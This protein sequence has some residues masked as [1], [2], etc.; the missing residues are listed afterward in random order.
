M[1]SL[2]LGV[3][4]I[5]LWMISTW[6]KPATSVVTAGLAI[7]CR[8]GLRWLFFRGPVAVRFQ[9]QDQFWISLRKI[10]GGFFNVWKVEKWA[11]TAKNDVSGNFSDNLTVLWYVVAM[12]KRIRVL[13]AYYHFVP[14]RF[15]NFHHES[16][17]R[18]SYH[19]Y[20][21]IPIDLDR[22][23]FRRTRSIFEQKH[24]SLNS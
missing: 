5:W 4:T 2:N 11:R 15:T 21:S 24:S 14:T 8:V 20:F 19:L 13:R 6:H 23:D 3:P 1:T 16:F 18:T 10:R 7:Y 9:N 17:I 22:H 12:C